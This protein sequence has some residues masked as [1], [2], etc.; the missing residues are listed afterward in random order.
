[1]LILSTI[2]T[3]LLSLLSLSLVASIGSQ[4]STAREQLPAFQAEMAAHS[5]YQ[6]AIRQ[7]AFDESWAGTDGPLSPVGSVTEFEI[8]RTSEDGE[9][10]IALELVGRLGQA[11]V[12]LEVELESTGDPLREQA[13]AALGPAIDFKQL[14]ING[15]VLLVDEL[16]MVYDYTPDPSYAAAGTWALGGPEELDDY[17]AATTTMDGVLTKFSDKTYGIGTEERQ[18]SRPVM[19]PAWDLDHYLTPG[20]DR[21][22]F[23]STT[24]LKNV[25]MEETAVFV[26]DPYVQVRLWDTEIRGGVVMYVPPEYDVR[27][28]PRNELYLK[29][30]NYLGYGTNGIHPNIGVVAPGSSMRTPGSNGHPPFIKGLTYLNSVDNTMG[31][32]IDGQLIVINDIWHLM[33]FTVTFD[34]S[35]V[36][37][38][39]IGIEY[40]GAA[41]G[42]TLIDMRESY[43]VADE[44]VGSYYEQVG[45]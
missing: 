31:G 16:E 42:L 19:M 44:F 2:I 7:L 4:V 32:E 33:H 43:D 37:N 35:I 28:G 45:D 14:V 40:G 13:I 24:Q 29:G 9:S 20:P 18:I 26:T 11:E 21:V 39:P 22:I 5:A 8:T 17:D 38:L 23:D 41:G 36:D 1:M 15:N 10:P 25:V 12:A 3:G 27:Q 34:E 6:Y 30:T